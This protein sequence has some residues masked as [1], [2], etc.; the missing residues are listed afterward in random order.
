M[1]RSLLRCATLAVAL[2][3]CGESVSNTPTAPLD[4]GNDLGPVDVPVTT[5]ASPDVSPMRDAAR[6]PDDVDPTCAINGTEACLNRPPGPCP[7]LAN[8][9]ERTVRLRGLA[10]DHTVSCAGRQTS[11]GPDAVLPLM[12]TTTSDVSITAVPSTGDTIVA[13]LAPA[14]RCG[15]PMGELQCVN[16]SFTIGGIA[17]LRLGSLAP[18]NYA[19][20]LGSVTGADVRVSAIVNPSPARAAGD[21]C[22]GV[23]ITPDGP[24]VTLDTHPFFTTADYGTTC[25]YLG[26]GSLGW[27]DAVFRFTTTAPRDVTVNVGGDGDSDLNVELTSVCGSRAYVLPGCDTGNP[28]RRTARNLPAGTWYVTVDYRPMRRPDHVLTASVTTA[29]P[30]PPGPAARCP[31]IALAQGST[32]ALDVDT[33]TAGP[34]LACMANQ[35][36]SAFLNFTAPAEP[37]DVLV[38]VATSDA[39]SNAGLVL[40]ETCGGDPVDGVCA[41]PLDRAASSV[42]A[43][44]GDLVPGRSYTVQAATTSA[45]GQLSTRWIRVPH[46]TPTAVTGNVTCATAYTVPTEGGIFTGTTDGA[47]AVATPWCATQ[48]TGCLGSRGVLYRL[49]LTERKRVVARLDGVGFDALLAMLSGDT[50][51]GRNLFMLANSCNDDWYSTDS[52]VDVTLNPGRYWLHAGGCGPSQGGRYQLDVAIVPP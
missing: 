50:C 30:T 31:G 29:P 21:L 19:L 47:T 48:T 34:E 40:R 11:M 9:L 41:G 52:Q 24:A 33:L 51:P 46:A 32:S 49:D 6:P 16:G 14:D 18:G 8:G 45:G 7:D 27:V 5:D 4:A 43:R 39:R 10:H 23:A 1:S 26:T 25:G 42:W 37:G 17:V 44:Y 2:A 36:V 28:A 38:N 22:P 20:I 3:G 35:R 12:I 13:A 15:D